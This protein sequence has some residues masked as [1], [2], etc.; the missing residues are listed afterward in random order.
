M[1]VNQ[2]IIPYDETGGSFWEINGFKPTSKRVH[3]GYNLCNDLSTMI[4][5]RSDIENAHAKALRQWSKK[6]FDIIGKGKPIY[7]TC[8]KTESNAQNISPLNVLN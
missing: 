3:D 1:S 2:D 5:E 7:I 8:P 4:K 6:W